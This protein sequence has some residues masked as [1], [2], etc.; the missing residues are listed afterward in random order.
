MNN[1]APAPTQM[2]S[3][4][5]GLADILT[6]ACDGRLGQI[7]WFKADWQRGGAATG[8]A[9]Y[10]INGEEGNDTIDGRPDKDK[11]N[12]NGGTD[13]IVNCESPKKHDDD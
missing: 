6:V 5:Q 7:T 4:A 13:T 10:K 8:K 9:K 11:C 3:L 12:G 1:R 2:R